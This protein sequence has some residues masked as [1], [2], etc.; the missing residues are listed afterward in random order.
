M[1]STDSLT[2]LMSELGVDQVVQGAKQ[3]ALLQ[4]LSIIPALKR[5]DSAQLG[6]FAYM[7]EVEGVSRLSVLSLQEPQDNNELVEIFSKA[8]ACW[9]AIAFPEGSG[10][11]ANK[12]FAADAVA[13]FKSQFE[14]STPEL[15]LGFHIAVSGLLSEK[16]PD[17]RLSLKNLLFNETTEVGWATRVRVRV[18]HALIL[19]C[20]KNKGWSDIEE[21]SS[22]LAELKE[23][24]KELEPSFIEKLKGHGEKSFEAYQLLAYYNAAQMLVL[25]AQYITD[26]RPTNSYVNQRLDRHFEQAKMLLNLSE[27]SLEVHELSLIWLATRGLVKNSIWSHSSTL[28]ETAKKYVQVI[29]DKGRPAPVLEL[30]PSQQKALSSSLLDPYKRVVLVEMPTSA[31]KTLVAKFSIIQSKALFPNG[32]IA[33][34][35]PTRALV[36]QITYELRSDFSQTGLEFRVEQTV[37]VIELDPLEEKLLSKPPDILVTTPEKLDLLIRRNHPS[38]AQISLIV[39]DEVHNLNDGNRG[40]KLEFLLA[41]LKRE[42]QDSRF[43]LLSPF[44]PNADELLSWLGEGMQL[45]AIKLNWRPS[46]QVIGSVFPS[47]IAKQRFLVFKTL[48][49]A[50][51]SSVSPGQSVPISTHVSE[52]RTLEVLTPAAVLTAKDRGT[53]LVVCR[54]RGT[55]AARAQQIAQQLEEKQPSELLSAVCRFIETEAGRSTTLV[56]CLKKGVAFHHAGLSPES[57]W[58]IESL[59]K[60]GDIDVIC[61][62]TTLAQGVNFPISTV[63]LETLKKHSEPFTYQDFWNIAGRAGRA[64]MNTSGT[65]VFPDTGKKFRDEFESFLSSKMPAD[66]VSQC[67]EI[68]ENASEI[69]EN[70]GYQALYNW[71]SLSP[72]LQFLSHAAKY[73]RQNSERVDVEDVL[74]S[75]LLYHQAVKT[76]KLE[77]QQLIALG[78]KYVEEVSRNMG[79]AALADQV[80]LSTP[81]VGV[82][83]MNVSD[84]HALKAPSNW[85]SN[86]LFG[87]DDS[88]FTR[89]IDLVS[90][91][92]EIS[93]GSDQHGQFNSQR[94]ANILRD[95]VGGKDL[96][97]IAD[98]YFAKE[99]D[100]ERRLT[101]SNSYLFSELITKASW[102]IASLETTC[103]VGKDQAVW[104]E[105]GHIPSLIFYG[106]RSKEALWLRMAG[107]PRIFAEPLSQTWIHENKKEPESYDEVRNWIADLSEAKW[108]SSVSS[109]SK[110]SGKDCKTI[111]QMLSNIY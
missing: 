75:S 31:G 110:L 55:A 74:R 51:M 92:P 12:G 44:I 66:I 71:K 60:T 89:C 21:A 62:T 78:N 99:P 8:Y 42:R 63:I 39:A 22:S 91:I 69:Q 13:V 40:A 47:K 65:V 58:L 84:E 79:T 20:R 94:I 30:W 3:A 95:W 41:T 106:V 2:S 27:S 57:R 87:K 35:V 111:W 68:I 23:L 9:K 105:V 70:I 56:D 1:N 73:A 25:T 52:K 64:M 16:V 102:A 98:T 108:R 80:G 54:G 5:F 24:Q 82:M 7:Y 18:K 101:Q 36:N 85:N 81:S 45:P 6:R 33:Y 77:A 103:L 15:D 29:T 104:N 34:V 107:L 14:S 90:A 28:S 76:S 26:G 50:N 59:I 4:E 109:K 10:K 67:K 86:T 46:E 88:L 61:G 96:Q 19:L 97:T 43:L 37:P 38:T 83:L 48:P 17:I 93:M 53:V 49:T 72:F 100:R 32:T 11:S